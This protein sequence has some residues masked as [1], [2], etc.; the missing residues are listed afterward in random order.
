MSRSLQSIHASLC[1]NQSSP[2][3]LIQIQTNYLQLLPQ[4]RSLFERIST[5]SLLANP[6]TTATRAVIT[7]SQQKQTLLNQFHFFRT[8]ESAPA[9][10]QAGIQFEF[11]P[12]RM[13]AFSHPFAG[14]DLPK[15]TRRSPLY[16]PTLTTRTRFNYPRDRFPATD[17][18]GRVHSRK[19]LAEKL[20]RGGSEPL[21]QKGPASRIGAEYGTLSQNGYGDQYGRVSG[22]FL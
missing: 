1:E 9:Q 18:L 2:C 17:I 8:P 7:R 13:N 21:G 20:S 6:G 14:H 19:K 16:E 12:T 10:L 3:V 5:L 15:F 11:P 4:P 22:A